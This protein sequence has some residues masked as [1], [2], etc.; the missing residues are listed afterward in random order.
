MKRTKSRLPRILA[1][2]LALTMVFTLTACGTKSE[3]AASS[4]SSSASQ[5]ESTGYKIGWS[6]IYMT[7]SWMQEVGD[8]MDERIEY[9]KGEGVVAEY[10]L[11][12]ANGDTSTQIS[13]IENMISEGYDAIVLIAGSAT[14]L[15]AVVDKCAENGVVVV[16]FDSL[17]T[18]DSITSIVNNSNIEYGQLCADWMGTELNGEGKVLVFTGPAGIASSEER[19]NAAIELLAEKYPNIEVVD[20]LNAEYNEAPALDVINPVLDAN[21]DIDGIIALGG[22]QASASLKAV[23]EKDYGLIPITGENYNGFLRTW[24]DLKDDGFSSIALA[25]QAWLGA[26]AVDQAVRILQGQPYDKEVMIPITTITDDNLAD[27]VP[28]D[29]PDDYYPLPDLTPEMIEEFLTPKV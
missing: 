1:M 22:S 29:Y 20:T 24:D 7:P 14:A 11:A 23:I 25:H 10:T 21:P 8:Y 28:N 2:T 13:Q 27:F 6:N 18:T 15:N 5:E 4:G 16:G 3:P 12:N 19:A 9:W 17:P 26:L